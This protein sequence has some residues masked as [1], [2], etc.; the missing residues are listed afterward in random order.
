M[1]AN[2]LLGNSIQLEGRYTWFDMLSQFSERFPDKSV[3]PAHQLNFIFCLQKDLHQHRLVGLNAT[4]TS[5]T[6]AT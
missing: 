5:G 6:D 1:V 4:L 2:E 3:G